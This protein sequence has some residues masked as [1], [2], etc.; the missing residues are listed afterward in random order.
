MQQYTHIQGY[1]YTGII[2]CIN[3]ITLEVPMQDCPAGVV[4]WTLSGVGMR[5]IDG[6]VSVMDC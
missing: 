2:Q 1:T 3:C 4:Q 6:H 5:W